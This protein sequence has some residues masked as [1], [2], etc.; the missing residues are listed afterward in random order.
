M[1]EEPFY[2]QS[3]QGPD[4]LSHFF[5]R[6]ESCIL[7]GYSSAKCCQR[8]ISRG[9]IRP[10]AQRQYPAQ[11]AASEALVIG[12]PSISGYRLKSEPR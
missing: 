7:T 1:I 6:S 4:I 8:I 9:M 2:N 3:I 5:K 12:W 11:P 10:R